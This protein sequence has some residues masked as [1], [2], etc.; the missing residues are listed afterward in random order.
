M[1]A[2]SLG[3]SDSPACEWIL[4]VFCILAFPKQIIPDLAEEVRRASTVVPRMMITTTILNGKLCGICHC[5]V[6]R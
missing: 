3:G 1:A 6:P 4:P 2:G 5:V